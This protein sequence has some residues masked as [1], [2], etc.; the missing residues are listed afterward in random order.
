M[1][2]IAK[3]RNADLNLLPVL[4]E[5]LRSQNV[6][7]TAETLNMSQSAAS[8]ALKRLR[9]QLGD[10]LLVRKGRAMELTP[11]ARRIGPLVDQ[12]LGKFEQVLW[13][14]LFDPAESKRNFLISTADSV[15]LTVGPQLIERLA[16]DAPG[17]SVR[18]V[19]L[20]WVNSRS[21]ELGELDF[22][23]MPDAPIKEL[24]GVAELS[25]EHFNHLLVYREEFVCIAKSGHPLLEDKITLERLEHY[26]TVAF[27]IDPDSPF[28]GEIPGQ[29]RPD[30]VYVSHF[31]LVP[32][33]VEGSDA[34]AFVSRH[35]AKI[36]CEILDIAY[37]PVP[38]TAEPLSIYAFWASVHENDPEHRWLREVLR[39]ISPGGLI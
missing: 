35:V 13:S 3:L 30:Q 6:T 23:I 16:R 36:F 26:Q 4:R 21:L 1:T 32:F 33:M 20:Q 37:N 15:I 25:L 39:E 19:D 11:L 38:I 14:E 5:L 31:S 17:M 24:D 18:F 10:D 29:S 7:R 34:V 9:S 22:V 27:R 12:A 8:E 2:V 28:Q